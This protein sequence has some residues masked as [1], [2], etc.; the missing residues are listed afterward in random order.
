[1]VISSVGTVRNYDARL[2]FVAK[3]VNQE[4]NI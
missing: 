1:M 2:A 4:M 3:T